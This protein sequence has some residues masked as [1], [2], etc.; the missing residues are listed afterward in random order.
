[1]STPKESTVEDFLDEQVIL[2]GGFTIKLNPR[3]YKGLQDRLV[4]LPHRIFVVELKRPKG[5]VVARLQGWWQQRF[6]ALG[7]EAHI[8]HTKEAVL[9]VL[10]G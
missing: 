8:A 1:M 3:G 9:K 4:V 6:R 7:H 5:G 2:R 10:D